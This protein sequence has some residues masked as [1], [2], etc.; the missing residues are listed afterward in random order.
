[1][2]ALHGGK[3]R[4]VIRLKPW[5]WLMRSAM[6]RFEPSSVVVP[7]LT[8]MSR[9]R[10][11]KWKIDIRTGQEIK[12]ASRDAFKFY[13]SSRLKREFTSEIISRTFNQH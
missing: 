11:G 4:R 12:F 1:M 13:D 10:I 2:S 8:A 3:H 6:G 9:Q 7:G 5:V